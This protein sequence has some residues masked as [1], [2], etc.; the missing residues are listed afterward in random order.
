MRGS[1]GLEMAV[2]QKPDLIILDV[3]METMWASYEVNQT[4]RFR[5]GY[6]S[7]RKVPN[8]MVSALEQHPSE[9]FARPDDR[10]KVGPDVI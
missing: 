1:E 10:S 2:T 3:M 4:L 9:R 5:S 8:V 6:E 7:V